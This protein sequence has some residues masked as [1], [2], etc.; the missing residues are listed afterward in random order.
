VGRVDAGYLRIDLVCF[1]EL[2][3]ALGGDGGHHAHRRSQG[4]VGDEAL[5]GGAPGATGAAFICD[6]WLLAVTALITTVY[7]V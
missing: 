2:G 5:H 4:A 6:G 7:L 3:H 1:E